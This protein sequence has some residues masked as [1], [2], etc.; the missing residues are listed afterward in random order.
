MFF[1]K[2]LN[3]LNQL[4]D[5]RRRPPRPI[6][7]KVVDFLLQFWQLENRSTYSNSTKTPLR[8]LLLSSPSTETSSFIPILV[9]QNMLQ[10]CRCDFL[11]LFYGSSAARPR[12]HKLR[13][14][15][16]QHPLPQ[17][18]HTILT[19]HNNN[20]LHRLSRLTSKWLGTWRSGWWRWCCSQDG[21]NQPT[22]AD[23]DIIKTGEYRDAEQTKITTKK[24]VFS[25]S[26]ER[27]HLYLV[28]EP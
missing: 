18:H 22:N 1:W 14:A 15:E 11:F 5:I 13:L 16:H 10:L 25:T 17:T 9:C 8:I 21:T 7:I 3:Q 2:L 26:I 28:F 19:K 24:L 23:Q 27:Q 20:R 4:F 6:I 12:S